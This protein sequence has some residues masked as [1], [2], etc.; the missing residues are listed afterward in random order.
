[1]DT[2]KTPTPTRLSKN[3]E[4]RLFALSH[5]PDPCSRLASDYYQLRLRQIFQQYTDELKQ[6]DYHDH[7]DRVKL[8]QQMFQWQR[9]LQ[10]EYDADI[11]NAISVHLAMLGVMSWRPPAPIQAPA[12]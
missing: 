7:S 12:A 3:E 4:V 11:N 6:H 5:D 8:Q 1:M 10:D 9:D 2:K